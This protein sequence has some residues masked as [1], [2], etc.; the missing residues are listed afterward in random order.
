MAI[1]SFTKVSLPYGWLGNMS[2]FP[3][4]YQNERWNTSEALF[5]ALR[6][7]DPEI[8]LIIRAQKSPMAAKMKAKAAAR[9]MVIAPCSEE[10]VDNMRTC[11]KLK[12]SQNSEICQLLLRTGEHFIIEDIGARRGSRHLFWGAHRQGTEWIG[13]NMM[14]QLLMELR[15]NLQEENRLDD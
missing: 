15:A 1:I 11:L 13:K 12:F 3:I 2:P 6:F 5:Q 8:K 4:V 14:G 7:S 9:H 10:D